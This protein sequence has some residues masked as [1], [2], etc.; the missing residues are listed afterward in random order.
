MAKHAVTLDDKYTQ[1][2]GAVFMSSVQA[3]VRLPIVQ[4]RRDTAAGLNTAGYITGYRGSPLGV[5]DTALWAA[6]KHL[7]ANSIEF[8]PGV[9][10]EL[11]AASVRG[12]QQLHW[13]D[14]PLYDGV[15]ALWYGKGL[16]VDRGH[17]ALKMGNFEGSAKFGG[18]LVIAG[19]DHGGKSS[20]TAHQS[21]QVLAASMIPILYPANTEEILQFGLYGIAM[22]RFSGLW[23]SL[24]GTN[25]TLEATASVNTDVENFTVIEPTDYPKPANSLNILKE[26]I[27]PIPQEQKLIRFRLPAAQAFVRANKLDRVVYDTSGP[28]ARRTLG[29][30]TAGKSYLD[31]RQALADLGISEAR[32]QLLG[33]RIYK[34]GMTWPVEPQGLAEFVRG[35]NEILVVEEKRAFI[36]DQVRSLLYNQ[37]DPALRP[38][39]TGKLDLQ[40]NMLIP[41]DGETSPAMLCDVIGKR[42]EALNLLE[43]EIGDLVTAR[44][45]ELVATA[46]V[47]S[48]NIIRT[49]YFCS[50]C[51]H[52]SSTV[53]PEG[54]LAFAGVGCHALAHFMPGRPTA[55]AAQMGAE[56]SLWIGLHHFTGI[57]H[58]FQNLG[59]GTYFHSGS[60]GIR[61]SVG[62][63]VNVTYKLLYNDAIAMTGGQPYDGKLTV[64]MMAR[65]VA[66]EGVQKVV[67]VTDQPEKYPAGVNWPAGLTIHPR[68]ELVTV[69][70]E[71]SN[72]PGVTALIYDQTCAA[73]KRRRRKRGLMVDPDKRTFIN[74]AVCEG[75]GD[76]S[77]KSNCVSVQPL[78]TTLGR[79][80][81]IDQS[82]CN[83]D[84]SCVT[85]FCPSFVTLYGAKVKKAE[86]SALKIDP[87]SIF[88]QLPVPAMPAL[89][90]NYGILVTGIGGT[91]VLTVSAI[92]G[93]AAHLEGR[94][95]SIMDMTGM[96]QKN[97]AVLSHLR[98]APTRGEIY[99]SRIG[100]ASAAVVIGCD[101]VVTA[102]MEALKAVRPGYTHSVV[103]STI[104][105][106]AQF[107]SNKNVDFQEAGLLT[108]IKKV[109]GADKVSA[110]DATR[111]ATAL[112]GDSIATNL[113]MVGYA[114]QKGLVPLSIATIE[115][116]IRLNGVAV[117]MNMHAFNWG[118]VA[119]NDPVL[120]EQVADQMKARTTSEAEHKVETLNDVIAIRRKLLTDYQNSAY[121]NK[122]SDLVEWMRKREQELMPGSERMTAAVAHNYA[123]VMAYKDEYE[124]ARLYTNGEF[125][126]NLK[127]TFEG[128]FEIKFNLA[129][130]TISKKNPRTGELIKREYPSWMMNVFNVLARFK[131]LRGT[132]LDI[133]G[134]TEE[135]RME[136]RLIGEYEALTRHV[137]EKFSPEKIDQ[138]AELL[139]L[140][141]DIRGYGHIKERNY[142]EVKQKESALLAKFEGKLPAVVVQFAS[143][144]A[145]ERKAS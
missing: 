141:D 56:G 13:F 72:T 44:R 5:Y 143:N 17:E 142:K 99:S 20:A 79:K 135:R 60:L 25:D 124:V 7:K 107:Q 121:A 35:H 118:R 8:I 75:C 64:D 33:L 2:S 103:N 18:V 53:V 102:G 90:D 28:T 24:K 50:G 71:L 48:A 12:S 91:G 62:A 32:A 45:N 69:E 117:T 73:E 63:G 52:N 87:E 49:A 81:Q 132:A 111:I 89:N 59:D 14:K 96:A 34:L 98:L 43:G 57:K 78:E 76:C 77:V 100:P 125:K 88:A 120:V 122:Y 109:N 136:R 139:S 23:V 29:I 94:G 110:V 27:F 112:L 86:K 84:F 36:E 140:Y 119:A 127:E 19:D 39:I 31:V 74:A 51:P 134:K 16:G 22:S 40:G 82:N 145:K 113:F 38:P 128:D 26:E 41:A 65:Q 3:L 137:I 97:G 106:T 114:V 130:P 104:V 101:M 6:G 68:S 105:P 9:N 93:M 58:A 46:S 61:A 92:L 85:G 67:I 80:R 54:H 138:A 55:W 21:E 123:K 116:A 30:V 133:F 15:F 66:A 47:P 1:E 95:C 126:Q 131:S 83:K 129:P 70:E 108:N 144:Q 37:T 4:K 11:A 115:E 10:E 42:L